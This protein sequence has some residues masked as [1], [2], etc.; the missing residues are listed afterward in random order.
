MMA[1][2]ESP[3]RKS[4]HIDQMPRDDLKQLKTLSLQNQIDEQNQ[5]S[6]PLMI[7]LYQ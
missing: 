5:S 3:K 6:E 7:N 2:K 4:I 1:A